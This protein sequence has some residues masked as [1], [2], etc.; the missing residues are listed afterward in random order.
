MK[1]WDII[2]EIGVENF[3]IVTAND[4]KAFCNP[5]VELPRWV[6]SGRLENIGRGVYRLTHYVPSEYDRYAEAVALVGRDSMI[7][8]VSVLAMHNLALV[9]PPKIVVAS[10]SRK[11]RRLPA[12]IEV[13]RVGGNVK[14]D[15]YN[16]IRIQNVADAI[17]TCGRFLMRDRI[18]DAITEAK[19]KGLIDHHEAEALEKE[20]EP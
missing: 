11:R 10:C 16:G 19:R 9:N 13:V 3:G 8:G 20:L 4:A 5:S 2:Y 1:H 18:V 15:N 12:W 17:R 14:Q 6:R 7:F